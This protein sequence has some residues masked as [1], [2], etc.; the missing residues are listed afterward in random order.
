MESVPQNRTWALRE[1]H[2]CWKS[3]LAYPGI[4]SWIATYCSPELKGF[5][6]SPTTLGIFSPNL[7]VTSD[8]SFIPVWK[9]IILR[10]ASSIIFPS[11]SGK[12]FSSL[13]S[14]LHCSYQSWYIGI[15]KEKPLRL[16]TIT[17][18]FLNINHSP[19]AFTFEQELKKRLWHPLQEK[20]HWCNM[21]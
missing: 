6:P 7:R 12:L 11:F 4:P 18:A 5:L 9:K 13:A 21:N 20:A 1:G 2:F 14:I 16:F 19:V 3:F 10:S 15:L 17:A 8:E